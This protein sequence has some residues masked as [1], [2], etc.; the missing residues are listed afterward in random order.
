MALHGTPAR[1]AEA[2]ESGM[3]SKRADH[4]NDR[5]GNDDQNPSHA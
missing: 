1:A 5:D 3:K 4:G 2:M